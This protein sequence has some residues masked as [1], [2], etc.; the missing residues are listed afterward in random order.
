M[1]FYG[2][3]YDPDVLREI[4][5]IELR[6]N[7]LQMAVTR[8][9]SLPQVWSRLARGAFGTKPATVKALADSIAEKTGTDAASIHQVRQGL[10]VVLAKPPELRRTL[11][12]GELLRAVLASGKPLG[13]LAVPVGLSI[14][15][16][17]VLLDLAD[18]GSP[19][20]AILGATGSGKSELARWL[21]WWLSFRNGP[22]VRL[23][24][25]SPKPDYADLLGCASMAHPPLQSPSEAMR[26]LAWLV[27]ELDRRMAA[28]ES[29]PQIV[30]M[31]DEVPTLL[32][33]APNADGLL[34]MIASAGR[35]VGIHLILATQRPSV[36]VITGTITR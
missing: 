24:T 14:L 13:R 21:L 4:V 1:N 36:N 5:S 17:P 8:P 33:V 18:A 32:K 20:V 28:G 10:V 16:E 26:L 7:G 11:T 2:A 34:D 22:A 6:A 3:Q 31:F 9:K 12:V 29:E 30:A 25:Y 35:A 15:G 27:F 23:L 19:H